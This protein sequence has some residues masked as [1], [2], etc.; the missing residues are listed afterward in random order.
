MR[1]IITINGKGLAF[2]YI[3]MGRNCSNLE[4]DIEECC[5]VGG[6]THQLTNYS[7]MYPATKKYNI[8]SRYSG[9]IIS[10]RTS[11][12]LITLTK[13]NEN[14]Q[15]CRDSFKKKNQSRVLLIQGRKYESTYRL[16]KQTNK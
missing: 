13:M 16:F 15:G 5:I 12:T 14:V 9:T 4:F 1:C 7:K 11:A 8:Y 6:P 10:K 2:S 3:Y